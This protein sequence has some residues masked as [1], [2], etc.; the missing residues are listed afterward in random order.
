MKILIGFTFMLTCMVSVFAGFKIPSHVYRA[1]E[2]E[3]AVAKAQEKKKA[4]A[5]VYTN[6]A[7]S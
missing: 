5:F 6:E 7:S 3:E 1:T 2:F 4:L